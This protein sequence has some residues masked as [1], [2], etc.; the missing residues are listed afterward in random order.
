MKD[1]DIIKVGVRTVHAAE[2]LEGDYGIF[3]LNTM[4]L[5]YLA[6]E[7]NFRANDLERLSEEFLNINLNVNDWRLLVTNWKADTIPPNALDYAGKTIQATIELFKVLEEKL[8]QEICEGDRTK[9]NDLCALHLNQ[10]Y[11]KANVTSKSKRDDENIAGKLPE[12]EIR[13]V[14]NVEECKAVIKQLQLCVLI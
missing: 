13:L 10:D 3:V 11:P 9:F 2:R 14:S 8:L 7:C 5:R 12:Q 6:K 1:E 4:D